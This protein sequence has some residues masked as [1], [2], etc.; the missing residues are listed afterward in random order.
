MKHVKIFTLILIL[1]T[2]L[3]FTSCDN[4]C[5]NDAFFQDP[6]YF[7]YDYENFAWGHQHY[8]WYVDNGGDFNYY[9][10]PEDWILPDSN[11][12]ISKEDLKSNL[13][14][15]DTIL[16]HISQ[17][18]LLHQINII[19][20]VDENLSEIEGGSFDG[21]T[22]SL[23]CFRWDKQKMKYQRILLSTFGDF[24]QSNHDLE[25][26]ELNAWLVAISEQN[27]LFYN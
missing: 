22:A 9:E 10:L 26:I 14:Q 21:G 2:G 15:A 8:G 27:H 13:H 17:N 23:Y 1:F 3:F 12:Y 16:Y 18:D 5:G 4:E 25:A 11:G 7:Q 19:E 24:I 6:V 20:N